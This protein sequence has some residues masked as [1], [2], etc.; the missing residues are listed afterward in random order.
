MNIHILSA[1]I[2]CL[3]YN[4]STGF[5][6]LLFKADIN[7][8]WIDSVLKFSVCA[9]FGEIQVILPCSRWLPRKQLLWHPTFAGVS[10]ARI[11]PFT[12][13]FCFQYF[14]EKLNLVVDPFRLLFHSVWDGLTR[15]W[16]Q[17]KYFC[18]T[19]TVAPATIIRIPYG[20]VF[21]E[22]DCLVFSFVYTM[23][24]VGVY[25]WGNNFTN[26]FMSIDQP[27]TFFG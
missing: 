6:K 17:E 7:L 22:N 24:S 10:S 8:L 26:M 2:T 25:I 11:K 14:L 19:D 27:D 23:H 9:T 13:P 5:A 15:K 21:I 1:L 16:G 12:S 3:I 20:K 18:F 4:R